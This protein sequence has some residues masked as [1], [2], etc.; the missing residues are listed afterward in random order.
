MWTVPDQAGRPSLV[1]GLRVSIV[2]D[3]QKIV[4]T[5]QWCL[6][7]SSRACLRG[8]DACVRGNMAMITW[9]QKLNCEMLL[10]MHAMFVC[11]VTT[12]N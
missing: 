9:H 3:E 4:T 7:V 2:A 10:A 5:G 12:Q 1:R 6:E 8:T 11:T